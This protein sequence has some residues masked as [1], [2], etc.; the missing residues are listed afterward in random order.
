MQYLG[1]YV[2]YLIFLHLK[3]T[4]YVTIGAI[5]GLAVEALVVMKA[6]KKGKQTVTTIVKGLRAAAMAADIRGANRYPNQEL[7]RDLVEKGCELREL[8]EQRC[9]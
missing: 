2:V 1:L 9:S 7:S 6:R 4:V 8:Q 3:L 5:S